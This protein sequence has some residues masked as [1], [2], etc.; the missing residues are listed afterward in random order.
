[1]TANRQAV[2]D[3]L[4]TRFAPLTPEHLEQRRL[5]LKRRRALRDVEH[6]QAG[7]RCGVCGLLEPHVCLDGVEVV[8]P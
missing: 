1:M 2:R 3:R 4:A 8:Q 7:P 5:R 6:E